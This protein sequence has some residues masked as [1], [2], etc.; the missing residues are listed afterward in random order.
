[1]NFHNKKKLLLCFIL[2]GLI[3]LPALG[4]AA[5]LK[6]GTDIGGGAKNFAEHLGY[7]TNNTNTP[8]DVA[9]YIITLLLSFVGTVFVILIIVSGFQW[10]TAGG[11]EETI[12]TSRKRIINATI[13]LVIVLA[14]F[15]ITRFVLF[16][17][18]YA[19]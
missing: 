18:Q 12:K 8:T 2:M 19:V 17:I 7:Q 9:A 16:N 3:V 13:G 5:L 1:M 10:M 6:E 11:N 15:V 14:A 4:H